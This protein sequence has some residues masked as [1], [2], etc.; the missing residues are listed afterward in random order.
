MQ[1][2]YQMF[3]AAKNGAGAGE[4]EGIRFINPRN[5]LVSRPICHIQF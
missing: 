4:T 1:F 5:A 3:A 2:T